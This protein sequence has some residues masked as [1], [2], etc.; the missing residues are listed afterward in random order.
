[1]NKKGVTAKDYDVIVVGGGV[2]GVSAAVSAAKRGASVLL[3]EKTCNLGGLATNGLISW[4]EPICNGLGKKIMASLSEDFVKIAVKNGY[5]TLDKRWGGKK[6]RQNSRYSTFFSPT[7][8]ALSLTEYCL[9]NGVQIRYDTLVT[10]PVTKE[11]RILGL[12]CESVSGKE[13]FGAKTVIDCSGTAVV[14]ERAG[15]PTEEGEN[16][17][18]FISH[19]CTLSDAERAVKERDIG[20]IRNWKNAAYEPGPATQYQYPSEIK[21]I[22][23]TSADDETEWMLKGQIATLKRYEN[24]DKDSRELLS[25][26]AMP[27]YRTIR[28]IKGAYEFI[29]LGDKNGDDRIIGRTNDV[30]RAGVTHLLPYGC[31]YH[32]DFPNLLAAG[33]IISASGNGWD[34]TRIIPVC[35]LTGQTAG[36]AAVHSIRENCAVGDVDYTALKEELEKENVTF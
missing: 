14:C 25:I 21:K 7:F 22:R 29:G 36:I 5:D 9:E 3:I 23:G 34:I 16:H 20:K 10:R 27:Q 4:Y 1:M 26:P 19:E 12:E 33:R 13:F 28:R 6:E 32:P 11:N 30:A 35:V 8:F 15:L 18:V 24:T 31:L 2:A 17:F